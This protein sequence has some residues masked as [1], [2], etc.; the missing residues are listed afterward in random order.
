MVLSTPMCCARVRSF[1]LFGYPLMFMC[2][3]GTMTLLLQCPYSRHCPNAHLIGVCICTVALVLGL[4]M[5]LF[6]WAW[7][8]VGKLSIPDLS[9]ENMTRT[10]KRYGF[11][12][13]SVPVLSRWL[14]VLLGVCT[15]TGVFLASQCPPPESKLWDGETCSAPWSGDPQPQRDFMVIAAIWFL[16]AAFGCI[17]GKVG[18]EVPWL[19]IPLPA[20]EGP[21]SR[22]RHCLTSVST[23]CH[24]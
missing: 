16:L 21:S 8:H 4:T 24:P 12:A 1:Y 2:F 9:P 7:G 19:Y 6:D 14:F 15:A 22:C 20:E 11:I 17:N 23:C 18:H 5:A 3:F 10:T 13:K